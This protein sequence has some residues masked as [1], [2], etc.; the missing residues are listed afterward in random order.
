MAQPIGIDDTPFFSYKLE[1]KCS[2]E[3]L[4]AYQII[5]RYEQE[6]V[7][8]SGY[9]EEDRQ[10]LIKYEGNELK[11]QTKYLWKVVVWN[12]NGEMSESDENYFET[13]RMK[14]FQWEAK[15]ITSQPKTIDIGRNRQFSSTSP[16]MRREFTISKPVQDATLYISGVGY[17][18]CYIN[19]T[20]IK[21]TVLD[22]AFTE[23]DKTTMYQ[24]HKITNLQPGLNAIGIIL[25]DGFYN[26]NT[27]EVWNYLSAVWRDHSKCI[28]VLNIQYEDGTQ[29]QIVSDKSFKG[30]NGP[31]IENDVRALEYY[32]ARMELGDWTM[33]GYDDSTWDTVTV[34]KG[35]G[36]ELVGQYTTPIRVV[37][38]YEPKE[39][40]KISETV[41]IA[42]VGFNTAGWAEISLTA[43]EGT[44]ISL[45]YG[46]EFDENLQ[47]T[48]GMTR[49]VLGND[50]EKFQKDIY[51]AKGVGIETWHSIFKYN[52]FRYIVIECKSGVPENLT[53]QIQEVRTDLKQAGDFTC[54]DEMTNKIQEITCR[55]TRTNFHGMPTDCPHREKIGWTGDA[56]LSAEQLL[57]NF[58]GAAAYNRWM[59]DVIRAQRRNGQLSGIIPSTGW[60]YN[61]GSGPVFDSV[62][63]VI[64]YAM[65][66]YCGDTRV[67][68][69]M[70][71]CVKKYLEF[72]ESMATDD[73]CHFG[74][75][76]WKPPIDEWHKQ[77]DGDVTDTAYYYY[78]TCIAA[79]MATILGLEEEA[80]IHKEN[81]ARIRE[82]FRKRFIKRA[83]TELELNC[84]KCQ[85]ALGC[86]V[87]FGLVNED[88][89]EL[90]I[91]ELIQDIHERDDHLD[92][93]V[94][95]TKLVSNVLIDAGE[96]E[97]LLKAATTTT[98]PSWGNMIS[99]GATTLWESW[100][101]GESLNHHFHGDIS[102]CFYKGIAGINVDETN[103]GFKYTIFKPQFVSQLTFAK[104]Y[105]M[106]PYG[107]VAS[108]WTRKEDRVTLVLTVPTNCTGRLVLPK[109]WTFE[110]EDCY[111]LDF[112]G[113]IWEF[114]IVLE[115]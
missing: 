93:G 67:L 88:E 82:S 46:E 22:P 96:M 50:R 32:D 92:V 6:V 98:Y 43:P 101:G 37:D 81:A 21:D 85:T 41:W 62:C 90:F 25:G 40:Q 106:T 11:P 115:K 5:V 16:Y 66:Q 112:G 17:Y 15:W 95:G 108:E 86:M 3:T 45:R 20:T 109:G 70:Y 34:T 48:R 60:G 1:A 113:G 78:D 71:P 104:A 33:P 52:G 19:G 89:K 35:P 83:D 24:T 36:G 4:K 47:H 44:E 94:P 114:K 63:T 58:D 74:L 65:Y 72:L 57:L 54:S 7:W 59:D 49:F 30:T 27:S 97:L 102:A 75:P 80:K 42:D 91:K 38:T 18:E 64:P 69:K 39:I 84:T 31:I 77:C 23:F 110:C 103:P 55:S 51:V 26:G 10:I 53:I 73:I 12:Q 68:E 105:H 107:K 28:C 56:Q 111:P 13:G 76:D 61:W 29:E 87:Y 2:G 9:I 79:K 14:P 99:Q 100:H 8:D